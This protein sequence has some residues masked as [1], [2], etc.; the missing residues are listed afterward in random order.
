LP[1]PTR[2]SRAWLLAALAV[3]AVLLTARD[4]SAR[5]RLPGL[6]AAIEAMPFATCRIAL[7][8]SERVPGRSPGDGS[9]VFDV[10]PPPPAIALPRARSGPDGRPGAKDA[11]AGADGIVRIA[12]APACRFDPEGGAYTAPLREAARTSRRLSP[13]VARGPPAL[14]V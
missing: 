14:R 2:G 8:E 5:E 7:D 10:D 11:V 9:S 4:G 6:G 12:G 13:H 3:L 1:A